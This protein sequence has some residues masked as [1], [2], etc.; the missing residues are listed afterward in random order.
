MS[1]QV[2][3]NK[4]VKKTVRHLK[5][6]DNVIL[7]R[8]DSSKRPTGKVIAVDHSKGLVKVEGIGETKRHTKPSQTNPKG[9]IVEG[10]RWWPASRF[11][12]CDSKGVTLG[13]VGFKT[14]GD[15]KER[16]FSKAR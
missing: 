10:L 5:K 13:R 8:A 12:V 16:V 9:G 2:K 4:V 14:V 1:K 3:K 7:W 11:R 15:K 6:D